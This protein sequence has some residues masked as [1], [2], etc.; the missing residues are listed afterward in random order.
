MKQKQ[1]T[2]LLPNQVT[3]LLSV[4]IVFI[5]LTSVIIPVFLCLFMEWTGWAD[6]E[7]E[8]VELSFDVISHLGFYMS[9]MILHIAFYQLTIRKGIR[10]VIKSR[11]TACMVTVLCA[12]FVLPLPIIKIFDFHPSVRSEAQCLI[13]LFILGLITISYIVGIIYAIRHYPRM[14]KEKAKTE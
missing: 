6:V 9:M 11:F 7:F 8:N 2:P 1:A 5:S 12:S 14:K 3:P 10:N 4:C 13:S